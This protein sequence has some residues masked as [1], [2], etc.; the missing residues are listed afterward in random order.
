[1]GKIGL[2]IRR[3]YMTRVKKKSFIIMTIVGPVLFAALFVVPLYLNNVS[4]SVSK[5]YVVDQSHLYNDVFESTKRYHFSNQFAEIPLGTVREMFKDSDN[6][7]VLFIPGNILNSKDLKLYAK[8]Q[9]SVN[10]TTYITTTMSSEIQKDLVEKNKVD[11][12]MIQKYLKPVNLETTINDR[13]S[14]SDFISSIGVIFGALIYFF[15]FLYSAQIMRGVIEEKSSRI[16]EVII[17]SVRPFQLMMGKIIGVALVGLTQFLLW[18]ILSVGVLVPLKGY[19]ADKTM[20]QAMMPDTQKA[21][22]HANITAIQSINK[23]KV[24]KSENIVK[25]MMRVNWPLMLSCFLFYFAG[26]YLL[27]GSLFAAIGAAVDAETDTQQFMLPVTAPLILSF[28]M[29]GTI[30]NNPDGPVAF[31]CSII[32]FT[33]PVVMMIRIPFGVQPWELALS[34]ASLVAGFVFTT[35]LAGKIYRTGILM[36]GKKVTWKELGKW[37]FYKG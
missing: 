17:S 32:P 5:V 11:T 6:A 23:E 19:I 14:D 15:V 35:W 21:G 33:A 2:I 24:S 4:D 9:P 12:A 34:M 29:I 37:L 28:A 30:L 16:V 27:Y 22:M 31:W 20:E 36:Y 1:M 7:Y 25:S 8:K 26:G 10:L 18:I 13:V 3:E